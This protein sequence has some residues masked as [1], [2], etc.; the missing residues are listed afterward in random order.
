[1]RV[2][3]NGEVMLSVPNRTSDEYIARILKGKESWIQMKLA[4]VA[5]KV[6]L[7]KKMFRIKNLSF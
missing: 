2:K 5:Q 4:I 6:E 1:M 3:P 7:E